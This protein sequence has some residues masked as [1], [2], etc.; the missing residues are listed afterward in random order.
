[1]LIFTLF[2]FKK[3]KK[4]NLLLYPHGGSGNHGCE[5]IVRSTIQLFNQYKAILFSIRP[6]QDYKVGLKKICLIKKESITIS[7]ISFAYLKAFLCYHVLHDKDAFEKIY[8]KPIISSITKDNL[9]LSIGG[10]NYCY[11]IPSYIYLINKICKKRRCKTILWGCSIEPESIKGEM[12]ND[13]KNY[14]HIFARESITYQALCK[15]GIRQ[16]SLFPDPAFILDRKDLPLPQGF[17]EY[18]TVGIN[19]SPLIMNSEKI[20]GITLKNYIALIRYILEQTAMQIA[21]I[22]HV[23]WE[24]NDDRKP[25]TLLYQEF[26]DTGRIVFIADH[27]AEELK[28]YIARCRFLVAARTHASIAAYSTQVP[29]LVIG[30]SVKARGIARDLFGNEEHYVLPVQLLQKEDELV[31]RFQWLQ[32]HEKEIRQHYQA[33]MPQYIGKLNELKTKLNELL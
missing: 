4:M 20:N 13:L 8:F 15:K 11:G 1:M 18:N 12:L 23:V 9:L 14:T 30:Y 27:N 7:K 33:F 10:D 5:A 3:D 29:T 26:K 16:V 6:E 19:L 22:P 2:N 31:K 17:T 32:A 21:L 25:L 28:G 24:Q